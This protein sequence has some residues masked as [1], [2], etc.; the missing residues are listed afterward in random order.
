VIRLIRS[1]T[2]LGVLAMLAGAYL[3]SVSHLSAQVIPPAR[4]FGALTIAGQPAPAGTEVKAFIGDAECGSAT[5]TDE[6][7]YVVDVKTQNDEAPGCGQEDLEVRFMVAGMPAAET[8][9]FKTGYF[10]QLDLTV[11]AAAPAP[12]NPEQPSQPQPEQPPEG[13]EPP[14]E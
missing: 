2:L 12:P 9:A 6:G 10:L 3:G 11:E 13:G 7:K 5:T 14:A 4:F 1:A 8:G